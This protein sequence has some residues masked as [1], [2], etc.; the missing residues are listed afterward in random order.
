MGLIESFSIEPSGGK[1][2]KQAKRSIKHNIK[3]AKRSRKHNI[4][5]AKRTRK[6]SKK[7]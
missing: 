1:S 5:Q 4:K 3:Q 2:K 6:H 7:Y